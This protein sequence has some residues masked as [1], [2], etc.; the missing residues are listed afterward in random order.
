[1]EKIKMTYET[2]QREHS[3]DYCGVCG[4]VPYT[5]DHRCNTSKL[6]EIDDMHKV[7]SDRTFY[8]NFADGNYSSLEQKDA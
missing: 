2:G 5:H 1:V 7:A 6:E 8:E 4:D 3:L